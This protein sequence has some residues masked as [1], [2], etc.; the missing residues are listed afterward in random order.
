MHKA[1]CFVRHSLL[2]QLHNV[3]RPCIFE[4]ERERA[5]AELSR[6]HHNESENLEMKTGIDEML[7][8]AMRIFGVVAV[9][10]A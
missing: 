3:G 4:K 5:R 1:N 6:F 10:I 7:S 8:D 2:E 9:I